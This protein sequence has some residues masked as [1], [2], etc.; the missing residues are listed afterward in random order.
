MDTALSIVLTTLSIVG[1]WKVY[2]KAEEPGWGILIP[3]YNLYLFLN[4]AGRSSWFAILTIGPILVG[5]LVLVLSIFS[6]SV[7]P[8][9]GLA[10]NFSYIIFLIY[11]IILYFR[12]SF[13]FAESYGKNKLFG[14]G[15]VLIP[16]VFLPIMGF[17]DS[18]YQYKKH[19]F[20]EMIKQLP[21]TPLDDLP[22]NENL[23]GTNVHDSESKKYLGKIHEIDIT[24]KK[25][26]IKSD[27]GK[28]FE[29]S[30][31]K[32]SVRAK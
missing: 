8:T 28:I 7:N 31:N 24:N 11:L 32:V 29:K 9:L 20:Q 16:F 26:I 22:S 4:I 13:D 17:D 2:E 10:V 15:I 6:Y 19:D 1:G 3:F 27:F 18:K 14:I 21:L 25:L 23:V 12:A 30:I 5:L